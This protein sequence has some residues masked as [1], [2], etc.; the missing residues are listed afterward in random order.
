[1]LKWSSRVDIPANMIM[2][3]EIIEEFDCPEDEVGRDTPREVEMG[4][5]E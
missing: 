3:A 4:D 2:W 5:R 1:M